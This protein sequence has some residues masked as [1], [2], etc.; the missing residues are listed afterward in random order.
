MKYGDY[1]DLY[2]KYY[3][4]V[5]HATLYPLKSCISKFD[6]FRIT[7]S[8]SLVIRAIVINV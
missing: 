7:I 4:I 8:F 3:I 6:S 5:K 1:K 2:I